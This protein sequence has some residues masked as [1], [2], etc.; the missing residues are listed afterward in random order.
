MELFSKVYNCYYQ[1]VARI[2]EE[3]LNGPVSLHRMQEICDLY[4]F[5]ESG[6]TI[7]PKLLE[8]EW[9]LLDEDGAR[10]S[11]IAKLPLTKLQLAW[12]RA[13]LGDSRFCL[14]FTAA[15]IAQLEETLVGVEPLYRQSDFICFDQ[16]SDGDEFESLEYRQNFRL[17][18]RGVK[19][20]IPLDICYASPR[21]KETRIVFM[22]CRIQYSGKDNKFRVYGAQIIN[23]KYSKLMILNLGRITLAKE[24]RFRMNQTYPI[25]EALRSRKAKEPVTL[26]I[27]GKR[28][29]L[30]R[31]MLHFA[32][33]EKQTV[34]DEEIGQYI[35]SIYY[36][37]ENETELLIQILSFGPVVKV[38]GP[39]R[40]LKM[41]KERVKRQYRLLHP[42]E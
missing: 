14:F 1:V 36:D 2:L 20:K 33:Y 18:L 30:E 26:L 23:G 6:L 5:G 32:N 41:V 17:V 12:I 37:Y 15:E 9:D 35:C 34:Y 29:S 7:I 10:I 22:P 3:A 19:N 38:A 31:S 8:G 40:F 13:L 42:Q 25:D 27:S 4:G 11:R 39:E 21:N 24:C 28:N 16:Y